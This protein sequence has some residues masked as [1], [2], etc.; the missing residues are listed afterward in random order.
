[1]SEYHEGAFSWLVPVQNGTVREGTKVKALPAFG[2]NFINGRVQKIQDGMRGA[3][4]AQ[5]AVT[6]IVRV[7]FDDPLRQELEFSGDWL[8]TRV[9]KR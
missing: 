3:G 2:K 9:K 1:M 4:R 5:G 7:R 6:P 8:T